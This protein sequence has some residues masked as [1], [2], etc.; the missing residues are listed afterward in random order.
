MLVTY[1]IKYLIADPFRHPRVGLQCRE[2]TG[3]DGGY[4]STGNHPMRNELSELR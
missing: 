1:S 2:Q 3:T 4:S